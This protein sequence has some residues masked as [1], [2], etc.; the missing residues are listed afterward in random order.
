M[1]D[2]SLFFIPALLN[3][4]LTTGDVQTWDD[5]LPVALR[6]L[7]LAEEYF[8]PDT[9][10]IR[11]CDRMGWCFVD[12]A[13]ELNKQLCAQAIWIYCAKAALQMAEDPG[14]EQRIAQR[15]HA[16]RRHLYDSENTCLSAAGTDRYRELPRP[17]RCWPASQKNRRQEMPDSGQEMPGCCEDGDLLHDA[18]LCGGAAP[19]RGEGIGQKSDPGILGRNDFMRR[20][21]VLGTLQSRK[22]G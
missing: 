18:S 9:Q 8:D 13:L 12:W 1:F 19:D 20:G 3:Y 16:A 4:V 7:E 5:L 11:D 2:Y 21:Y 22:P 15:M 17:G 14:L 6:Q 10:L